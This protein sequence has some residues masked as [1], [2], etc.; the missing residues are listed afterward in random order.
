MKRT[1]ALVL[2]AVLAATSAH[3]APAP[4]PATEAEFQARIQAFGRDIA[5]FSQAHTAA[6]LRAQDLVLVMID[7]AHTTITDVT[8]DKDGPTMRAWS[9]EWGAKIRAEQKA[10]AA[11]QAALPTDA[12]AIFDRIG[13]GAGDP[14]TAA[15]RR[16]YTRLPGAS[17]SLITNVRSMADLIVPLV[18]RGVGGD[19]EALIELGRAVADGTIVMLESENVTLDIGIAANPDHPQAVLSSSARASNE[20]VIALLKAQRAELEGETPDPAETA[21]LVRGKAAEALAAAER[22]PK[23]AADFQALAAEI[24]FGGAM[25]GKLKTIFDS[26]E[27]S[28]RTEA[29]IAGILIKAADTLEKDGDVAATVEAEMATFEALVDRRVAQQQERMRLLAQ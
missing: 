4:P 7:G 25:K 2:A 19:R 17:A 16:A 15:L 29:E 26:Y 21:A 9:R 3:A 27:A 1:A 23:A 6:M 20:A 13:M 10:L 18:D 28:G 12:H 11:M 14:R 5:A 8:A 24:P 22:T